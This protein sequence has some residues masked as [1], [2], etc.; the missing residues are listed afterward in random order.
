MGLVVFV[1][2][3]LVGW[4]FSP[5]W[6]ICFVVFWVLGVWTVWFC[7]GFC[8]PE[9]LLLLW[10]AALAVFVRVLCLFVFLCIYMGRLDVVCG[11][12]GCGVWGIGGWGGL[13]CFGGLFILFFCWWV[14]FWV[15]GVVLFICFGLVLGWFCE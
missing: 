11:L 1:S 14:W 2:F 12:V 9:C 3:V 4:V 6:V 8:A 15:G 7:V 10:M 5:G 13:T